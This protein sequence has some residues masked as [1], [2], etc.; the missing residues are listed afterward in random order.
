MSNWGAAGYNSGQSF[1]TVVSLYFNVI[2]FV[3]VLLAW[4]ALV[5]PLAPGLTFSG[6]DLMVVHLL[7]AVASSLAGHDILQ[8]HWPHIAHVI[9][10]ATPE[11][12]WAELFHQY[13]P[14]WLAIKSRQDLA[15]FYYG[16]SSLYA[17][18]HLRLWLAP[19]FWWSSLLVVLT[20]M[21]VALALLVRRQWI[22]HEK[23]TY[24]IIQIPLEL[25]RGTGSGI[26]RDRLFWLGAVL[27]GAMNLLNGLHFL[28]PAVPSVGGAGH[29]ADRQAACRQQFEQWPAGRI[30]RI[31][32]CHGRSLMALSHGANFVL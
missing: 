14:S 23:L 20:G 30:G 27:A 4:N 1:P 9:W 17:W 24:P 5:R 21:M 6:A 25:T 13:V 26:L 16:E 2:F 29:G 12:E 3:I 15:P 28:Y 22:H 8:I 32:G 11:N 18:K 10:Y 7:L 19:V 31:L